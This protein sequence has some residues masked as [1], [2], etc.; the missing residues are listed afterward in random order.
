MSMIVNNSCLRLVRR[1]LAGGD[2]SKVINREWQGTLAHLYSFI[3][4]YCDLF[5]R[6]NSSIIFP[7]FIFC[8]FANPADEVG[9]R[10][11][12]VNNSMMV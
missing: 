6:G 7:S 10:S 11:F 1:T 9:A 3:D 2:F 8:V 12:I 4:D 5:F